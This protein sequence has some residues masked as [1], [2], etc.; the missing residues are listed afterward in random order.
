MKR[1]LVIVRIHRVVR[2]KARSDFFFFWLAKMKMEDL[3]AIGFWSLHVQILIIFFQCTT[4]GMLSL[5]LDDI[6]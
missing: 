3:I 4:C 2:E 6:W 1:F 5:E